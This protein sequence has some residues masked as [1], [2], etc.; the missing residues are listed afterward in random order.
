MV[1]KKHVAQMIGVEIDT[2]TN[3]ENGRTQAERK[4]IPKIIEFIGYVPFECPE[5]TIGRLKYLMDC[6]SETLRSHRY[7]R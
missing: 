3:W 2:V 6:L 7:T 1:Y 4:H 5:D